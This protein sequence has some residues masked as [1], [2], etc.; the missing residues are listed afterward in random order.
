M[1]LGMPERHT[2]R[3]ADRPK[4]RQTDKQVTPAFCSLHRLAHA[5]ARV[6]FENTQRLLK[7]TS[8]VGLASKST[9]HGIAFA[10]MESPPECPQVA[11]TMISDAEIEQA[12]TVTCNT[13][14]RPT[15]ANGIDPAHGSR[16]T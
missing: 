12:S 10:D 9:S 4:D 14:H 8:S 15:A 6:V 7:E 5:L 1:T 16:K 2:D 3:N 11:S 13:R